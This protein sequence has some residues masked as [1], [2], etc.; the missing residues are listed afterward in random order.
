M[1]RLCLYT[2]SNKFHCFLNATILFAHRMQRFWLCME[3]D[4][5][6]VCKC[7][8]FV[9]TQNRMV[10]T[11]DCFLNAMILSAQII[12]PLHFVW[13]QNCCFHEAVKMVVFCVQS[14]SLHSV[15]K[16][17]GCIQ[18]AVKVVAFYVNSKPLHFVQTKSLH[19]ESSENCRFLCELKTAAFCVNKIVA[20]RQ[21]WK[22]SLSMLLEKV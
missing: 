2:E 8:D 16:Q 4:N 11:F 13:K 17:N 12:Q 7:N 15:F 21:Q 5:F 1:Q 9:C 10:L 20:F 6:V 18:K 19:S 22:L 3:S 14:K